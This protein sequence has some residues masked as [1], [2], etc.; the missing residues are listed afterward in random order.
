MTN[1]M[2]SQLIGE[3]LIF[4]LSESDQK[5]LEEA[6]CAP[7][8]VCVEAPAGCGKALNWTKT[9]FTWGELKK[10]AAEQKSKGT[11]WIDEL[12]D[13]MIAGALDES[14]KIMT[15]TFRGRGSA[16]RGHIFGPILLKVD[17]TNG[18]PC[19][20]HFCLQ[21]MIVPELVRGKGPVGELF[22]L[23]HIGTR[24][25]WEVIEPYLK[26]EKCTLSPE[27][28]TDIIQQVSISLRLIELEIEKFNMLALE[29]ASSIF[30]DTEQETV[31]KLLSKRNVIKAELLQAIE[32]SNFKG[33]I[34]ELKQ[35]RK[36]NIAFM[37]F[38]ARKYYELMKDDYEQNLKTLDRMKYYD[39]SLVICSAHKIRISSDA[40]E[41]TGDLDLNMSEIEPDLQRIEQRT[42]NAGLLKQLGHKLY[43]ALFPPDILTVL[44]A[45]LSSAEAS[46]RGVRLRLEFDKLRPELAALPWEMLYHEKT[47]TFLANHTKIVLSRY[48]SLP[49]NKR[50][51]LSTS[52]P[53]RIL[54]V[55]SKPL[56]LISLDVEYEENLI[57]SALEGQIKAKRIELDIIREATVKNIVW[58][59]QEKT[60]TIVHFI[61]HGAFEHDQGQ[62]ALVDEQGQ[63]KVVD[64]Q[65]FAAIFSGKRTLSMLV[66]NA[67]QGAVT[68][69]HRAFSGIAPRLVQHGIPAVVAMQYPILDS[70]A[71]LFANRFYHN[72]ALGRPVDAAIQDTRN[73]ISIQVGFDFPDFATPV[74]YMQA[75]EGA[76]FPG[77]E[78]L[79]LLDE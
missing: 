44:H 74:L 54:L 32:A 66:L 45:S 7:D 34:A 78:L 38:V 3:W 60:Y 6:Q 59:L 75:E 21:E 63:A 1:N 64:D 56:D 23:L 39:I 47:D 55:I 35:V 17:K 53:L 70:T 51:T 40:G 12:E 22:N 76:I 62:I 72:L 73:F 67:C 15:S 11:Y 68:S 29:A 58:R 49:S 13:M 36:L 4:T 46:N 27:Q 8:D 79:Q 48:L 9:R 69:S 20:Y 25:R 30:N 28:E 71:R 19:R 50:K 42:T 41:E 57:R 14:P 61:G 65:M 31:N 24:L 26:A 18:R 43:Q 77:G 2:K 10:R 5:S 37:E 16:G 33:L 52:L